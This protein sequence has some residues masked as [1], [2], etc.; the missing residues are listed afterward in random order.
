M[1][2]NLK[3]QNVWTKDTHIFFTWLHG[4]WKLEEEE[5]QGR[6]LLWEDGEFWRKEP[7]EWEISPFCVECKDTFPLP[8]EI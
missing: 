1:G 2:F 8:P 4:M 5:K 6:R 7:I 3:K